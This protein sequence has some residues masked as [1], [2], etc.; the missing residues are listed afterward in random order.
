MGSSK[1]ILR[2]LVAD[3][4]IQICTLIREA[5]TQTGHYVELCH[6]GEEVLRKLETGGKYGL[7]I[8]DVLMP[9]KTGV[10]VIHELRIQG[11]GIPILLMSSFLSEEVL[12]SFSA[13]DRIAFLQKP[14]SLTDLRAT[15]D[16]LTRP[17]HS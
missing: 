13:L 9:R 10:E 7:L 12:S 16:R 5:L 8:L 3:D 6:D 14:F 17:V 11:E 1:D 2:I 15:V 4:E